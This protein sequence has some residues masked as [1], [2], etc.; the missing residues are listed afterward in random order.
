M[1]PLDQAASASRPR[2][3]A[4][5]AAAGAKILDLFAGTQQI[6]LPII[7]RQRLGKVPSELP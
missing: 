1:I 6:Q 7:P 2:V 5:E 3:A 4:R